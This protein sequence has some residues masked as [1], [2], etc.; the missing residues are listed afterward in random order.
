MNGAQPEFPVVVPAIGMQQKRERGRNGGGK[1]GGRG[2]EERKYKTQQRLSMQYTTDYLSL[3]LAFQVQ[4]HVCVCKHR[5]TCVLCTDSSAFIFP[6][7][8]VEECAGKCAA[9]QVGPY[10]GLIRY[11]VSNCHSCWAIFHENRK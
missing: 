2:R 5:Q 1:G 3:C 10:T 8:W 4:L 11:A 9:N 7:M 6:H